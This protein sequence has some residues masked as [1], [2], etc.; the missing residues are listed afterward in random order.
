VGGSDDTIRIKTKL[1]SSGFLAGSNKLTKAMSGLSRSVSGA[2]NKI[3][4]SGK[5]VLNTIK[6]WGPAMLGITSVYGVIS[7]A[8][9]T[10][11][12]QNEQL[13][14]KFNSIWT[15]LGNVLAPVI[16]KIV[17]LITD[18]V[19]YLLSF[20]QLLG[21]TN[22][23]ASQL[24]KSTK[25]AKQATQEIKKTLAGFDEL[26]V[27][28]D[29]SS[30]GGG[31]SGSGAGLDDKQAPEW[32]K[33]LVDMIKNGEW[34]KLAEF[35]SDALIAGLNKLADAIAS[36][37][38][39]KIGAAIREFFL[40]IKW[41]DIADAIFN[42]L[43]TAWNAAL[44]LLWG[45]LAGD[46]D[47]EPP[48]IASLRKIGE[49]VEKLYN[50]CKEVL[51]S[52]WESMKPV[53]QQLVNEVLPPIVDFLA[54]IIGWIG[55]FMSQHS[56][57]VVAVIEGVG[58]ALVTYAIG[59]KMFE[60]GEGIAKVLGNLP[61]VIEGLSGL[62]GV[63]AANPIVLIVALIAGLIIAFISLYRNNEEF[64]EKVD[65]IWAAI[66][67]FVTTTVETIKTKF[68]EWKDKIAE[69]I[70]A[71]REK[72]DA[73]KDKIDEIK[74]KIKQF[75][76]DAVEKFNALRDKIRGIVDA[77]RGF[78]KFEFTWPHLKL[79]H[80]T[81]SL[82]DVPILGTIPDPRTLA[83][84]WYKKGGIVDGASLIGAG[85]DGAEAIVP[86]E[87]H[88][89]WIEKVARQLIE[90]IG[91]AG[92]GIDLIGDF[93]D[94]VASGITAG[95]T[96]MLDRL[97]AI[98]ERVSF[99]IPAVAAGGVTPYS[100]SRQIAMQEQESGYGFSDVINA[101]SGLKSFLNVSEDSERPI[102]V[103]VYL[104]GEQIETVVT[105]RQN[106]KDRARGR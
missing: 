12:S 86:L 102:Q 71:I 78:F 52:L 51:K 53:L 59:S 84:S 72:I 50:G 20:L 66:R 44:D 76:D 94:N 10:F 75:K 42:V 5:S 6:K 64:R 100:V 7:K 81:Y 92:N 90:Q 23:S 83:V 17:T 4:K 15:A 65:K 67:Q 40:H 69:V 101:I 18:A 30:G 47:V 93:A 41:E 39:K 96:G 62:W 27:L 14:A 105:R 55:D 54:K 35:A 43:K 79:P 16:E 70:D 3:E 37:D 38:W 73:F 85:E 56:D 103:V 97:E 36:V 25:S 99:N 45:L 31:D 74:D 77:I 49:A 89:E 8:V 19:S 95:F 91:K 11:M 22:K 1:D 60:I 80:I 2:M 68:Q 33:N 28:Q 58:A 57:A 48:L 104:D 82:I 98:A 87:N 24:S 26:N 63:L 32:M 61:A 46:T 29:S 34:G 13:S 21:V 88:T 106:Q 9:S